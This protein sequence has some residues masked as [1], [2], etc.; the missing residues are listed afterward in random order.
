MWHRPTGSN[1]TGGSSKATVE[2]RREEIGVEKG[3]VPRRR[4][5]KECEDARLGKGIS[6]V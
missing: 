1:E 3:L 4:H 2:I 6:Q 5:V